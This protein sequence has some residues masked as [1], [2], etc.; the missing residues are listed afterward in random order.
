MRS[1]SSEIA[2]L[3]CALLA[4]AC[5]LGTVPRSE[6]TPESC[7]ATFGFGSVCG[8]GGY[9][10]RVDVNPRCTKTFPADLFTRPLDHPRTIVF[11]S[12]MDRDPVT[13]ASQIQRE[14]AIELAIRGANEE[15]GLDDHP[16][17]PQLFG[18]V[19]C[20]I[21]DDSED[22]AY[23]SLTRPEAAVASARYLA[24]DLDVA[25]IIG[26]SA[27][28]DSIAVFEALRGSDTLVISPASTS[29][30]LTD[31]DETSPTDETPGLLWRTTPIDLF[32]V[33]A[34]VANMN[35][36]GVTS[37]AIV[38]ADD[39]YGSGIAD[40]FTAA[41]SGTEMPF[42]F[43]AESDFDRRDQTAA[44]LSASVDEVLF[45]SSQSSH[46][47]EF[48][49]QASMDP[50]LGTKQLFLTDSAASAAFQ[51]QITDLMSIWPAI[52]GTRPRVLTN[53][54]NTVFERDFMATYGVDASDFTF[55]VQAYD[56]A[57]LLFIASAWAVHQ[58][59]GISGT[60]LARGVRHT[61][62]GAAFELRPNAFRSIV[63][64][65]EAGDSVDVTGASGE[66]QYDLAT[67]ELAGD[68]E[69]WTVPDL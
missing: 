67:E 43:D 19:F 62:G 6:C 52:R 33:D 17:S 58:E 57:W 20:D 35:E 49:R 64:A 15:G 66:L 8:E 41:F 68:F 42:P 13:G 63:S 23:D 55:T 51:T 48:V 60:N 27:S 65:F 31:V 2:V 29:P 37:V 34:M 7:Q 38:H 45:V 39:A 30:A 3:G 11:G 22:V 26:P 5:S 46:A 4:T 56:A 44:G 18:V 16:T 53:E 28:A 9:C 69:I 47:A 25:A 59:S 61:V 36:R 14:N 40:A 54:A 24:F 1:S 50:A 32:Q 21:Q 12:L 10:R